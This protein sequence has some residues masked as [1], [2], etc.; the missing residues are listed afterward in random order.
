MCCVS[1]ILPL[2]CVCRAT[3][4]VCLNVCCVFKCVLCRSPVP[5]ERFRQCRDPA[6]S[7]TAGWN[8]TASESVVETFR[9][10][11][12]RVDLHDEKQKGK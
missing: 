10:E 7:R 9:S 5:A 3:Y 12:V 6:R 1:D 2:C 4:T 11:L 8:L